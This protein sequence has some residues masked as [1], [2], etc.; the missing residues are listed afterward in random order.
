MKDV[1]ELSPQDA[2]SKLREAAGL[3]QAVRPGKERDGML[4]LAEL[5]LSQAQKG[6]GNQAEAERSLI[7]GY[8]YAR[9]SREVRVRRFAEKLRG[10]MGF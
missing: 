6:L 1:R 4:A 10:E 2:I 3:L 9:T 7:V 8:S 5:R